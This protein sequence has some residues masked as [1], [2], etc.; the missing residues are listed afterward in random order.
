[1]YVMQSKQGINYAEPSAGGEVLE[2]RALGTERTVGILR[3]SS[4]RGLGL[5]S[6]SRPLEQAGK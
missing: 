6:L 3:G 5:T 4:F 2:E 1:M